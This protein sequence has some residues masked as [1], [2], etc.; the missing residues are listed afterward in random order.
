MQK[1]MVER[2]VRLFA[3]LSARAPGVP[4]GEVLRAMEVLR[5]ESR[6]ARSYAERLCTVGERSEGERDRREVAAL[7]RLEWVGRTFNVVIR[8]GGDPR[9]YCLHLEG[10]GVPRN[11]WG[12]GWA[13]DL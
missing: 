6:R 3:V 4:V 10:E 2:A 11:T 13:V 1:T 8:W 9:G 12:D 7:Q 5:K